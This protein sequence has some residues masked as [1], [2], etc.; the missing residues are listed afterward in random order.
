MKRE[1][2]TLVTAAGL[3]ILLLFYLTHYSNT[4][5]FSTKLSI[6]EQIKMESGLIQLS[7]EQ[8]NKGDPFQVNKDDIIMFSIND[9]TY[10]FIIN[11]IKSNEKK[12]GV[13]LDK[14]I[15]F[16]FAGHYHTLLQ[17]FIP[18]SCHNF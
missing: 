18:P 17:R 1:I 13:V 6:D 9:E 11:E 3:A 14:K 8:L 15:I 4:G 10:S 5:V 7:N 12:V 2:I 16:G